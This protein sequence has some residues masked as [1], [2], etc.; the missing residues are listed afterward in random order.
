LCDGLRALIGFAFAKESAPPTFAGTATG[1]GN[2]GNMLGGILDSAWPGK[3]DNGMGIYDLSAYQSGF[4]FMISWLAIGTVAVF[5][6]AKPAVARLFESR[7]LSVIWRSGFRT[8]MLLADP[9]N[10]GRLS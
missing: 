2:M 3:L 10:R 7:A 1:I 5:F 6:P 9:N 8:A 4:A